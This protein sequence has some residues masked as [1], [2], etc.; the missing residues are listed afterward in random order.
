MKNYITRFVILAF[1][2]VSSHAGQDFGGDLSNQQPSASSSQIQGTTSQN[3][4]KA[5]MSNNLKGSQEEVFDIVEPDDWLSDPM[6][7]HLGPKIT[8]LRVH[9]L[10]RKLVDEFQKMPNLQ[11]LHI[12]YSRM[13]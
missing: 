1:L 7:E 6:R 2:I 3:G 9:L 11:S 8:S 10:T 4:E 5:L 12:I 13:T